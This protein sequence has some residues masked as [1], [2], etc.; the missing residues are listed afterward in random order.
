MDKKMSSI[1]LELRSRDYGRIGDI[2]EF[3]EADKLRV[4]RIIADRVRDLSRKV[5]N[6]ILKC[7][8]CGFHFVSTL[9]ETKKCPACK[10]SFKIFPKNDRS[11]IAYAERWQIPYIHQLVSL[12]SY[13]KY[14][15]IW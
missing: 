4:Q 3:L 12:L 15:I 2:D 8:S 10:S 13:G 14:H 1:L 5:G 6:V 7:P 11:R 9:S